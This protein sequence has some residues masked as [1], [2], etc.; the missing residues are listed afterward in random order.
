MTT[1]N[2]HFTAVIWTMTCVFI[3]L[4]R[5]EWLSVKFETFCDFLSSRSRAAFQVGCL[6]EARNPLKLDL[7]CALWNIVANENFIVILQIH[8]MFHLF[9]SQRKICLP[10]V[11]RRAARTICPKTPPRC[12]LAALSSFSRP[13]N[14]C[15]KVINCYFF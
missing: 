8:L 15:S 4:Q 3:K 7:R 2:D 14:T 11:S 9:L 13:I 12:G 5:W 6:E 10:A 1:R